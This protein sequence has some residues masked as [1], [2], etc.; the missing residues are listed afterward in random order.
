MSENWVFFKQWLKNPTRL[1]TFLP[2][3]ESFARLTVQK[4]IQKYNL[5]P[6]KLNVLELGAGTGR[7]TKLLIQAGFKSVTAVELDG[8]LSDF[9]NE[10]F[11]NE[12]SF[13]GC[14]N[15][16]AADLDKYVSPKSMD[17]VISVIPFMYVPLEKRIQ[18]VD[19]AFKA[20]KDDGVFW[21]VCY[22]PYASM[23][24]M[25]HIDIKKQFTKW[26]HIPIGF[27]FDFRKKTLS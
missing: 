16:D 14:L 21:H 17:I 8:T 20:L 27:V 5:D 25:Y 23:F 6:Q 10:R 4:L 15:I 18:I 12:S 11:K 7:L 19:V 13:Q 26:L 24:K 22:T 3:Q 1:G 2:I 9:L